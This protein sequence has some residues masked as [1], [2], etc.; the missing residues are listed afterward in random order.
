MLIFLTLRLTFARWIKTI[1]L[2]LFNMAVVLKSAAA[3]FFGA[4]STVLAYVQP[5]VEYGIAGVVR[6][7]G[8]G[9]HHYPPH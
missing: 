8:S 4:F 6:L 9:H 5:N 3:F 2:T 7:V 1:P